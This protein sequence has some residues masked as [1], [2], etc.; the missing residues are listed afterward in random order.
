[1]KR[2]RPQAGISASGGWP[3]PAARRSSHDSVPMA[4]PTAAA[5]TSSVVTGSDS[6]SRRPA[7]NASNPPAPM[8]MRASLGRARAKTPR[9][10]A[11][12]TA[13][14]AMSRLRTSL[15]ASP[16]RSTTNCL[17]PGGWSAITRSPIAMIG[18]AA[19]GRMPAS[20]SATPSAA[21]PAASPASA[22][23][24]RLGTWSGGGRVVI[25]VGK[26]TRIVAPRMRALDVGPMT[27]VC[28]YRD[29]RRGRHRALK[30]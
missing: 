23:V 15:S 17:A 16:K 21:A 3:A 13:T 29:D 7:P 24:A 11:A 10:D 4:T 14:P 8:A 5:T 19:P 30:P 22:P 18:L 12:A 25:G 2:R 28:R 20:S 26:P 27:R 6:G 1:M 9:P